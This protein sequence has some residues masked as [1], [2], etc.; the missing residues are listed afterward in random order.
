MRK[1]EKMTLRE[2]FPLKTMKILASLKFLMA[3]VVV[4]YS[5]RFI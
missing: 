1:V 2:S 5:I 3:I 4:F